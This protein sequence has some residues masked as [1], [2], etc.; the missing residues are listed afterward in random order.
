MQE[1]NETVAL[2]HVD[3]AVRFEGELSRPGHR[4]VLREEC[5]LHLLHEAR[6]TPEVRCQMFPRALPRGIHR[7]APE[8]TPSLLQ[9][10]NKRT[11]QARKAAPGRS[12]GPPTDRK[13]ATPTL[14]SSKERLHPLNIRLEEA[15]RDQKRLRFRQGAAPRSIESVGLKHTPQELTATTQTSSGLPLA[16]SEGR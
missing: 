6:L 10:A 5:G 4:R 8:L 11:P 7:R 3:T 15:S 13:G 16:R 9:R 1:T 2:L 12:G 14:R